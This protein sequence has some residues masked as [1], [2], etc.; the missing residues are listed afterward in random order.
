MAL[1]AL[2][3]VYGRKLTGPPVLKNVAINGSK[4]VLSF[5]DVG[6]G[7][8]IKDGD[9]L[10][11]FAIAGSDKKWVWAD[12][13][14]IGKDK[15]EVSSATSRNPKPFGMPLIAILASEFDQRQWASG[16]AFSHR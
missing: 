10:D 14:I 16:I 9:K 3:D 13:K 2:K 1:W 5:A 6:S 7:L 12:A 15:V 11:E 4:I 8:K